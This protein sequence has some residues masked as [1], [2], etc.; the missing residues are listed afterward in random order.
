MNQAQQNVANAIKAMMTTSSTSSPAVDY[1]FADI[2]G[3]NDLFEVR[4]DGKLYW[5]NNGV[6]TS[7]TPLC[8]NRNNAKCQQLANCLTST[9]NNLVE[10][11]KAFTTSS[12][13]P[14]TR[15]EI[16]QMAPKEVKAVLRK[17]DFKWYNDPSTG[18][19]MVES[20]NNWDRMRV[21]PTF[22]ANLR[23]ALNWMVEYMNGN[24]I[25]L[26]SG[27]TGPSGS[28]ASYVDGKDDTHYRRAYP[29]AR[30]TPSVVFDALR[31]R[32]GDYGRSMRITLRYDGGLAVPL[33]RGGALTSYN[34]SQF[35]IQS[36][37]QV[38]GAAI[39]RPALNLAYQQRYSVSKLFKDIYLTNLRK[40]KEYNKDLSQNTKTKVEDEFKKLE[41]SE[42]KIV[43]AM[44]IVEKFAQINEARNDRTPN[45][46]VDEGTLKTTI[47]KYNHLLDKMERRQ[48]NLLSI[49]E[50]LTKAV[51]DPNQAGQAGQAEDR[52]IPL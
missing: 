17:F 2:P 30:R 52:T 9:T 51:E 41:T 35:G 14:F 1:L 22:P 10:C 37:G 48:F 27:Y 39:S 8:V 12:L 32:I 24:P 45:Q 43:Q 34:K 11:E 40:L 26:N 42:R 16:R 23:Q 7:K 36:G 21:R 46:S 38:G 50:A 20:I 49:I 29:H 15:E 19:K 5:K 31:N 44:N 3:E 18:L 28:Q 6:E 33:F 13:D 47:D 4:N 25:I